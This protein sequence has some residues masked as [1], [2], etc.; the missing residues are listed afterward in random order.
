M[1]SQSALSVHLWFGGDG[2]GRRGGACP[3][4]CS[5]TRHPLGPEGHIC[6]R[7]G[8]SLARSL[9]SCVPSH[10]WVEVSLAS[11]WGDEWRLTETLHGAYSP[12]RRWVKEV[13]ALI[14]DTNKCF[15]Y[16]S[17]ELLNSESF[18]PTTFARVRPLLAGVANG[19]LRPELKAVSP[20]RVRP[21]QS[22]RH[23]GLCDH[24]L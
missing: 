20:S 22:S 21:R 11:S 15:N 23:P 3:Q 17:L 14:L 1:A 24:Y 2:R 13:C 5:R 4:A 10:V 9:F 19:I 18:S 7:L 8:L 16:R 6:D 12:S